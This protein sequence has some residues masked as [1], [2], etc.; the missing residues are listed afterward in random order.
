MDRKKILDGLIKLEALFNKSY[1][2]SQIDVISEKLTSWNE[3]QFDFAINGCMENCHWLPTLANIYEQERS[4][5]DAKLRKLGIE[6][7]H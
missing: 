6:I 2:P 5:D 4:S 3:K 7:E 1:T